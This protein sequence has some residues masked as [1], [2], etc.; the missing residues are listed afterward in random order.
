MFSFLL[1]LYFVISSSF[2]FTYFFLKSL[3]LPFYSIPLLN[4]ELLYVDLI[5]LSYFFTL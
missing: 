3:S 2:S 1:L 4:V 5:C